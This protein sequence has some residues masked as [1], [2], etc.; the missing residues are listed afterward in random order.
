MDMKKVAEAF[1]ALGHEKRLAIVLMLMKNPAGLS[2]G[3]IVEKIGE[4]QNTVS[5]QLKV[6]AQTGVLIQE[7]RGRQMFYQV[8]SK[9]LE[10]LKTLFGR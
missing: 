3:D 5:G 8:D 7:Q 10:G 2:A 4:R 6:L 9:T 1:A